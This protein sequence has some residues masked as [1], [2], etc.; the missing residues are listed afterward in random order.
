MSECAHKT[1]HDFTAIHLAGGRR[2]WR[3]SG[4][5]KVDTWG[6][7][8]GYFGSIECKKCWMAEIEWVACSKG[9][10]RDRYGD[11]AVGR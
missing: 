6:P 5:G 1:L 2:K 9:C 8:W 7:T 10:R 4:C 11:E 3:C